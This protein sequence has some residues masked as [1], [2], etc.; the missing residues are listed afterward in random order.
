[1]ATL[2]WKM[3]E[4]LPQLQEEGRLNVLIAMLL[5]CNIRMR[6]YPA[7]ETLVKDTGLSIATVN[8]GKNWLAEH[9]F[10]VLVPFKKRMD[11]ELSLSR[12]HNV[13][14]LTGVC[15]VDG[16]EYQ[17]LYLTDVA[18]E[19][20]QKRVRDTLTSKVL[21]SK[22]LESKTLGGKDKGIDSSKGDAPK[23][24]GKKRNTPLPPQ[25][26][27]E[28]QALSDEFVLLTGTLVPPCNGTQYELQAAQ[29]LH[30]AGVDANTLRQFYIHEYDDKYTPKSLQEIARAIGAYLKKQ[31]SR[32][33]APVEPAPVEP[34]PYDGDD[35]VILPDNFFQG[36]LNK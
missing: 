2:H 19:E 12:R 10:I 36:I 31:K 21:T 16:K 24:K 25:W 9:G 5:R 1:M 8:R 14:Q 6:C 7:L 33:P 15:T 27:D 22:V 13:Y 23:R 32:Q 26:T 4:I 34:A 20:L 35:V 18:M 29:T 3:R 28:L 11:D 17:Y 30:N